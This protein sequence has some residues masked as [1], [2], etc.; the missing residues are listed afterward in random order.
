LRWTYVTNGHGPVE[1]DRTN[2]EALPLDG[3]SIR[4]RGEAYDK[5]LGV[6]GPSLIRYRLGRACSRFSADVGID[7]D[8][9]GRGSAQFE[10]WGDGEL[11]FQSGTLTGTSPVREVSVDVSDRRELR[12]FVGVGGDD[13]ANDHAVWAGARLECDTP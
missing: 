2:G 6:H 4:L 1:L 3:Q 12:L 11:L 10:V 8:Q 5:G 13:F 9:G 7:D